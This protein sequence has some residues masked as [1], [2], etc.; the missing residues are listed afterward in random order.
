MIRNVDGKI[1]ETTS[2]EIGEA[3]PAGADPAQAGL[4]VHGKVAAVRN[5]NVKDSSG[6]FHRFVA[7]RMDVTD[8]RRR[9]FN[10][11]GVEVE[12][13]VVE[14]RTKKQGTYLNVYERQ[15]WL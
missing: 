11:K 13:E 1:T 7:V 2:V 12:P 14:A 3:F 5:H 8:A 10:D 15:Y 9:R 6:T 4:I